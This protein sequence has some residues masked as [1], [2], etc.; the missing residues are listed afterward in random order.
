M[1]KSKIGRT[2]RKKKRKISK[3]FYKSKAWSKL[4]LLTKELYGRKCMKCGKSSTKARYHS[5]H[6]VPRS[7]RPDLSLDIN[8]IQILCKH[9]NISKGNK[10]SIDYRSMEDLEKLKTYLNSK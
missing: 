6:L 7:V 2:I 10:N 9:C 5:D 3:S 8:N 4:A 1:I